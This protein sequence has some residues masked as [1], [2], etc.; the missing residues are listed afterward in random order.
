[1]AASSLPQDLK[2]QLTA[3]RFYSCYE[4]DDWLLGHFEDIAT[5]QSKG[6]LDAEYIKEGF[7]WYIGKAGANSAIMRYIADGDEGVYGGFRSLVAQVPE[8]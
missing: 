4:V 2:N 5:L 8:R 3:K 6:L 1:M 7:S